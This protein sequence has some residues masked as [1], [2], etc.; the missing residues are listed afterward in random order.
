MDLGKKQSDVLQQ[1]ILRDT[2]VLVMARSP[3]HDVV[4]NALPDPRS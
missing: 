4:L 2:A 3:L 1:Q